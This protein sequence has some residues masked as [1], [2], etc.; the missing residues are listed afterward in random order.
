[1]APLSAT[2]PQRDLAAE[3]QSKLK[4]FI[5]RGGAENAESTG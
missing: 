4:D 3:A 1:M 5:G 2:E